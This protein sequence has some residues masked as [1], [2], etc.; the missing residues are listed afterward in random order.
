MSTLSITDVELPLERFSASSDWVPARPRART[1]KVRS[2]GETHPGRVREQNED[3]FL[4]ARLAPALQ[5]EQT[6]LA[7]P[8][9]QY[10]APQGYLLVV[11]DGVG[12]HAAGEKAS[13]LA[14]NTVG[15][16]LLD[17]LNW[18]AQLHSAGDDDGNGVLADFQQA[19]VRADA[20][21]F[22]EATRQPELRG[23]GTTLTLAYCLDRELFV[24]HVGDSRCYLLR[25]GLL[26]RLTQDHTLVADL[27]RRGF[28][29]PDE[30]TGHHFRHVIT[31]VVGGSDPG[32]RVEMHKLRLEP[33]DRVLLCSDG[34][35][36]MVG[37]PEILGVLGAEREPAAACRRLVRRANEAG[38]RDNITAVVADF[39]G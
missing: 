6:S 31:N 23:M 10:G 5:A 25:G 29:R 16:F 38:G 32:V 37:D 4:I 1:L 11:A 39:A 17:T 7:Q 36:E 20:A 22:D 33:G 13:A 2:H 27:V 3:H 12:G 15:T 34:L 30:A 28:L 9:V 18:C 26:Y 24:A 35:T 19:L 14:V 8:G 21:L